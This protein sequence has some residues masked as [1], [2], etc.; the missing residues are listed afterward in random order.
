MRL[1]GPRAD[2]APDRAPNLLQRGKVQER[3]WEGD[4]KI[5]NEDKARRLEGLPPI[6]EAPYPARGNRIADSRQT[7]AGHALGLLD[8][9]SRQAREGASGAM[10]STFEA[11]KKLM[12][13]GYSPG[14]GDT[15]GVDNAARAGL[16]TVGGGMTG[17]VRG[18]VGAAGGK[19]NVG[20]RTPMSGAPN[21]QEVDAF[22]KVFDRTGMSSA[23]TAKELGITQNAVNGRLRDESWAR[24]AGAAEEGAAA[25]D[26]PRSIPEILR[27]RPTPAHEAI[28]QPAI[29]R[30]IL[31][32]HRLGS[33]P[34]TIAAQVRKA[35]GVPAG[36]SEAVSA[37]MVKA[38][39]NELLSSGKFG[40][41]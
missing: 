2:E 24:P 34:A 16:S 29:E 20:R 9:P 27:D 41:R 40:G 14:T 13:H 8:Y 6:P 15:E 38:K 12:G 36:Q 28:S 7:P 17:A 19:L 18:A 37:D 5:E 23:K 3:Q 35:I 4:I 1:G 21:E 30:M 11:I 39:I 26:A 31:N 33:P 25:T 32:E 22:Y 10:Q